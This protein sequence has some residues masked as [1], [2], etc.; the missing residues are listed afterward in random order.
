MKITKFLYIYFVFSSVYLIIATESQISPSFL[1]AQA[2]NTCTPLYSPGFTNTSVCDEVYQQENGWWIP[3]A[4][5]VNALCACQTLPV[6]N[7]PADC[8]RQF[9]YSR[10]NDSNRYSSEFRQTAADMKSQYT[11]NIFGNIL[12]YPNYIL[13]NFTP[14]IYQDHLEAYS[15]KIICNNYL[16]FFRMLLCG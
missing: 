16:S 4:Y 1:D 13:T 14:L 6:N 12:S 7:G 2:N 8:I 9:L 11:Q 3:D 15:S 10:I 5:K